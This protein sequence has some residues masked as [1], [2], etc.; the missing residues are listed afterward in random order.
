MRDPVLVNTSVFNNH[1]HDSG[2]SLR[3][4]I[5]K[6]LLVVF[7]CSCSHLFSSFSFNPEDAQRSDAVFQ[8]SRVKCFPKPRYKR[9]VQIATQNDLHKK[10]SGKG[11]R[12]VPN[13]WHTLLCF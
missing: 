12:A 7:H 11:A 13:R 10:A 3:K 8:K 1:C 6:V 5:F 2:H 9:S 4:D